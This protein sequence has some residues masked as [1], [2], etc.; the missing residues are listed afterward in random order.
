MVKAAMPI[1]TGPTTSAVA[2]AMTGTITPPSKSPSGA[3]AVLPATPP[4]KAASEQLAERSPQ[5]KVLPLGLTQTPA[6]SVSPLFRLELV[7]AHGASLSSIPQEHRSIA[8]FLDPKTAN[9]TSG[10]G[11]CRGSSNTIP[12]FRIGRVYQSQLFDVLTVGADAR[13]MISREHFRVWTEAQVAGDKSYTYAFIL[14]NCSGNGTHVNGNHLKSTGERAALRHGDVVTLS[15]STIGANG[16]HFQARFLQFRFEVPDASCRQDAEVG[17]R[18]NNAFGGEAADE[19]EE[20]GSTFSRTEESEE[21]EDEEDIC[22]LED[23]RS[24]RGIRRREAWD[25]GIYQDG[26]VA[27]VLEVC[28]P[29]VREQIPVESR[30]IAYAPPTE[31]NVV[32]NAEHR[33]YSSLIIGRAHQLEFWQE[34]LRGEAFNTLSRQHFEVQTW[35]S[36]PR[37]QGGYDVSASNNV[38]PFSFLVRNLSDVNPVHVRSGP[39][40]TAEDPAFLN[41]GEQRHLLDGDEIVLNIDQEHTFWLIFRD[42]TA[43]TCVQNSSFSEEAP[44]GNKLNVRGGDVASPSAAGQLNATRI[45]GGDQGRSF[46]SVLRPPT[47]VVVAKDEDEISTTATPLPGDLHGDDDEED[48]DDGSGGQAP[49][50]DLGASRGSSGVDHRD[51][52]G[53]RNGP[54]IATA[55]SAANVPLSGAVPVRDCRGVREDRRHGDV[56]TGSRATVHAS[57]I[58]K[59]RLTIPKSTGSPPS[60]HRSPSGGSPKGVIVGAPPAFGS[61][62]LGVRPMLDVGA[63]ANGGARS[64]SPNYSLGGGG[65]VPCGKV[66]ASGGGTTVKPWRHAWLPPEV[67]RP[68]VA[69]PGH[70]W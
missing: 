38:A 36:F 30:R 44:V 68:R 64:T 61:P 15:R 46:A 42:F 67:Q 13:S 69:S 21:E 66:A 18:K 37:F 12:P 27:F 65:G 4:P 29:A 6:A 35:R 34:V 62:Q 5:A 33:L 3:S 63:R 9:S 26:D 55:S 39:Q 47:A 16:V 60:A 59:P 10:N 22:D 40:E 14:E 28:G 53:V 48:E 45:V 49:P 52:R 51:A 20:G 50:R 24:D 70:R 32:D 58:Y 7:F 8:H 41:R 31:D 56:P 1:R 25:P 23:E 43:S 17:E 57:Q 54:S 2:S 19:W 11:S